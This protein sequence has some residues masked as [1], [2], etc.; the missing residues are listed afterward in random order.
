[1]TDVLV[2]VDGLVQK[3]DGTAV[4]IA[5]SGHPFILVSF[6]TDLNTQNKIIDYYI[7]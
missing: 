7:K 5:N 4:K 2:S 3:G 1:M 6:D